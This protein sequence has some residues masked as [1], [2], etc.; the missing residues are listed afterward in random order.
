M[1]LTDY[2]I[3]PQE[4]QQN[5]VISAPD[6][7][8]GTAQE[9]KSVFDNL[10]G[11][12]AD[13][14]NS[15]IDALVTTFSNIYTKHETDMQID[16]KITE[17]GAGDMARSVYDPRSKYTDIFK[18]AEDLL[19]S[20]YTKTQSDEKFYTKTVADL[21]ETEHITLIPYL[22]TTAATVYKNG[23]EAK[24]S[25]EFA[26]TGGEYRGNQQIGT[27]QT[28]AKYAR[29]GVAWE[30]SKNQVISIYVVEDKLMMQTNIPLAAG[31]V[32]RGGI[33]YFV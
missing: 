19:V 8:T 1:A 21:F 26:I 25:F 11:F 27:L 6:T 5:G 7:L 2:K 4:K 33:D 9:N 20:Y 32:I 30:A 15:L 23:H 31:T 18:Y 24:A 3:T 28:Q 22:T 13:K 29:Y 10:V 16:N 12:F 14:Y 17:I